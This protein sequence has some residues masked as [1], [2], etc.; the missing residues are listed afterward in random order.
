MSSAS[1]FDV[2]F[3]SSRLIPAR[4]LHGRAGHYALLKELMPHDP[5]AFAAEGR[6]DHPKSGAHDAD[7][8]RINEA[9][10]RK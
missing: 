7:R 3:G 1:S 2:R 4:T 5:A 9:E 8:W 6:A 10:K